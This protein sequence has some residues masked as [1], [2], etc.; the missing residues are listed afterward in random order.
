MSVDPVL[1][2]EHLTKV[3]PIDRGSIWAV[4]GV[5]FSIG[6]GETLGL[7][8]ES[9]SGKTTV[10]R[11][12]LRLLEP[13]SGTVTFD[14]KELTTLDEG[15]IRS[16][17]H[18]MTI[19]FQDP[20]TSLNPMRTVR[21]TVEEALLIQGE[22][23]SE[24]REARMSQTL[25]GVRLGPRYLGRYPGEMTASEQQR[26]AIARALVTHPALVVIDEATS[27]LDARA[28]STILDVLLDLQRELGVSY[29]FISH[30]LTAVERISHRIAIMY[31]G[32]IVEEAGTSAIM[33]DAAPSI[34]SRAVVGRAV[35][36]PAS[37]AGALLPLGRDPERDRSPARVLA[38]RP[39]PVRPRCVSCRRATARRARGGPPLGVHPVAGVDRG[40][41]PARRRRDGVPRT[42]TAHAGAG[43]GPS[44]P[45]GP[46]CPGGM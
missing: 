12:V 6:R 7:V 2:V 26:L 21:Q 4:N 46:R 41:R 33:R 42:V 29:L 40:R 1:R 8:G 27:N 34:Q 11:C 22:L 18:R 3:F 38:R 19:V 15:G 37:E 45:P 32:R 16:L 30:D 28:R 14:G 36:R 17:R 13:T 43:H 31:L 39:L 44:G 23:S 24:A 35:P 9:G 20:Y 25:D 10:G 5:S